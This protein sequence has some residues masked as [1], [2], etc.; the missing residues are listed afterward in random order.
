M[1]E[2]RKQATTQ[3]IS[4][5]RSSQTKK[6][7][8]FSWHETMGYVI[9]K[10][11]D[12]A[13]RI[14]LSP[15]VTDILSALGSTSNASSVGNHPLVRAIRRSGKSS[16]G[17]NDSN[18]TSS[19]S[20][21]PDEDA[22]QTSWRPAHAR[23]ALRCE[24]PYMRV[25][26]AQ[27]LVTEI[28]EC[29]RARR[30]L[31]K[32]KLKED[33]MLLSISQFPLLGDTTNI[34]I[35][36]QGSMNG[37]LLRSQ[38]L[39]DD[40][41]HQIPPFALEIDGIIE[42]RG[43]VPY[44]AVPV[45]HDADTPWPFVD[46]GL[47]PAALDF[48]ILRLPDAGAGSGSGSGGNRDRDSGCAMGAHGK[49]GSNNSGPANTVAMNGGPPITNLAQGR[50]I[51]T[52]QS[53]P[54]PASSPL[55]EI[56]S[57]RNSLLLDSPLFGVG[58]GGIL[59]VTLCA[60][61]LD[62]ARI[63][64]DHLAPISA[65]MIA[66]TAGT[67]IVRGYL[68]DR[69]SYWDVQ[70]SAVDDRSA[71]ERGF[72]P[73]TTAKGKLMKSRFG[74]ID[75]YLGPGPNSKDMSFN[76]QYNDMDYTYDNAANMAM[77]GGGV[78]KELSQHVARLFIRDLHFA[79]AKMLRDKDDAKNSRSN[80]QEH[81]KRFLGCNRQNVCLYPPN[82]RTRSGWEVE[83]VSLE[84][85]LTDEE[86][87]AFISFIV[88]LSRV[89]ISY[90]LNL[91]L[92]ISMMN[93]N[94]ARAQQVNAAKEQLFYFR[95]DLFSGRDGKQSGPGL[96]SRGGDN[97]GWINT[98]AGDFKANATASEREALGHHHLGTGS[99]DT[100]EYVELTINEILNGSPV[101]KV[102]GLLTIVL[103]YLPSLGLEYQAENDLRRQLVLIRRRASGKLCTL[104]TWMRKF[105]QEHPDYRHDSVVSPTVNY[106]MLRTLNDIEEGRV[107]A[108]ELLTRKP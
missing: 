54:V 79:T 72:A 20:S 108:P 34:Y 49:I 13:R 38:L 78:D 43:A 70:C 92:P 51:D 27:Q 86:N 3:F 97:G 26:S 53:G 67:P 107:A 44:T 93:Q 37:P 59:R 15:R 42:R 30:R 89:I 85:Q 32:S 62:E 17:D 99:P 95:R 39:S 7:Q 28:P 11:D 98:H 35:D 74:T 9:V 80:G 31:L 56:P 66:L 76:P 84:V 106:D 2:I 6:V 23:F 104:A 24:P 94:M 45:F 83:F 58:S 69:D 19:S 68:T 4:S 50:I 12:A 25:F 57:N 40:C 21:D 87:A 33:E 16:S 73:L 81:F 91:Y 14:V 29:L 22:T 96:I 10:R 41:L 102:T 82:T 88:L 48:G 65:I 36:G 47:S 8:D 71:Q 60:A 100:A 5:W 75:S 55:L 52:F 1:E 90:S 61:D 103:S 46:P 64:Y 63:L 105:V 101:H 18:N 77:M